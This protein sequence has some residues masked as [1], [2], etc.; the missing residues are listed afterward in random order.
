VAGAGLLL[1]GRRDRGTRGGAPELLER[2]AA[3][4]TGA[5]EPSTT[6]AQLEVVLLARIGPRTAAL[7]AEA[8]RA[9]FA[10]GPA[11]APRHPR[12]R[13]VR[14]VVGDVGALRA[15]LVWLPVP[16]RIQRWSGALSPAPEERENE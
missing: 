8:E 10:A 5:V 13:V 14:A 11:A 6:L 4:A 12:L 16:P 7:A 2:I 15:P 1:L 3:G 9:R